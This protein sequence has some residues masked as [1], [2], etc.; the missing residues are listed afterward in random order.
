MLEE[1]LRGNNIV[2]LLGIVIFTV[3]GI[4]VMIPADRIAKLHKVKAKNKI[5][6]TVKAYHAV[7]VVFML[8]AIFTLL[9]ILV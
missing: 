5:E 2:V 6:A 4:L 8:F 1:I 7:G 9:L 3:G